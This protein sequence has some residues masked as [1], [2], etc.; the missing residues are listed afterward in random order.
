MDLGLFKGNIKHQI[1]TGEKSAIKQ[2]MRR[3]LF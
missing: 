1:H 3:T 2:Q